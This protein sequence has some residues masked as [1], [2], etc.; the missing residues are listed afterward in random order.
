M[1]KPREDQ[2]C[3]QCDGPMRQ[4]ACEGCQQ[5]DSCYPPLKGESSCTGC[6]SALP[7]RGRNAAGWS[8]LTE[9][10]QTSVKESENTLLDAAIGKEALPEPSFSESGGKTRRASEVIEHLHKEIDDLNR[11]LNNKSVF[12]DRIETSLKETRISRQEVRKENER[13]QEQRNR[14][15]AVAD[16][17]LSENEQLKSELAIQ[18]AKTGNLRNMI[19]TW[20]ETN[21][22][23]DR[24]PMA[25][26]TP[27]Y[28]ESRNVQPTLHGVPVEE[29]G[30]TCTRCGSKYL[31]IIRVRE[32]VECAVA[33]AN[34]DV[35][36]Y[37]DVPEADKLLD[38]LE[39]AVFAY[40]GGRSE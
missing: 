27:L 37:D 29:D 7:E 1:S 12:A 33:L 30:L 9:Q 31:E 39:A 20:A 16:D 26:D 36:V 6:E 28:K 5:C 15:I 2:L 13:L 21:L 8:G 22:Q 34:A 32:V 4:L 24:N 11:R 35:S 40:E 18:R 38:R 19:R 25:H 14:A 23:T 17:A 10:E 3:P